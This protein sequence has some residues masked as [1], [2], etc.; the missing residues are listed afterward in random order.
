VGLPA[1]SSA[2]A[3]LTNPALKQ[4]LQARA[5]A[6][7]IQTYFDIAFPVA[8]GQNLDTAIAN[9]FAKPGNGQQIISSVSGG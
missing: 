5:S 6:A 1:N 9:F 8:P 3:V 2:E 4:V 7:Y